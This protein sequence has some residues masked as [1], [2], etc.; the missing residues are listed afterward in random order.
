MQAVWYQRTGPA[1]EVLQY[2]AFE[3]P[4]AG[5]GEVRIRLYASAVNPADTNRRAGRGWAM[6][7]PLVIPNSDGAGVVD[8]VGEGV[9]RDLMGRRVWLYNGQRGRPLGTAAQYI[10]L[11]HD[12][13]S[14]LPDSLSFDE[15][16]CLGIPCMTAW[17]C[18]FADGPV[19]G[20]TVLVQ[21]GAGAVGHFAVQLAA[22]AGARVLTT[23]SDADKATHARA[24]GAH[25]VIN[26]RQ[27]PLR[28]RVM[29]LT[30]GRGVDRVVE[31]DL[32]ANLTDDIAVLKTNGVLASYASRSN[33]QPALPYAE[34]SRKN[35]TLRPMLLPATPLASR[36]A[37][38]AGISRWLAAGSRLMT[39]AASFALARTAE[40]HEAVEAGGKR[41]TVIVRPQE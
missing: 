13:V 33:A 5:A 20:Q 25:E 9:E 8:Q 4:Q 34:C 17:H 35:I 2:G 6:D 1:R 18:L 39:V 21:G 28:E 14:L 16:A 11:D 10:T 15:G 31:V 24:G 22:W 26:Y 38:Q 12:L 7:Y 29:T 36:Q 27:E 3:T 40:A 37:A 32:G 19:S 23:V 30:G 41:G